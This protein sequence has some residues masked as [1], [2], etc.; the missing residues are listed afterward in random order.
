MDYLRR[1][2]Y[3]NGTS[4]EG[5]A[6]DGQTKKLSVGLTLSLV[7]CVTVAWIFR[8]ESACEWTKGSDDT[9]SLTNAEHQPDALKMHSQLCCKVHL[10]L[11]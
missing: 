2:T 5:R 7:W 3:S 8:C 11:A 6:T 4:K 10:D 9:S 1:Y